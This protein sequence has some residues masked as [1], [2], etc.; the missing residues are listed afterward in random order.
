MINSYLC[1]N[2]VLNKKIGHPNEQPIFWRRKRDL[3]SPAGCVTARDISF[4]TW[5]FKT[6]LSLGNE[7]IQSDFLYCL[8]GLRGK[9]ACGGSPP[10]IHYLAVQI[11]SQNKKTEHPFGYSVF[12]AE[13]EGFEPSRPFPA[14][15][16]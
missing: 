11:P 3:L 13:K 2:P 12:L 4:R 6:A 16:P 15:L 8:H 9:S 7:R 14:L 10:V 5:I 1:S